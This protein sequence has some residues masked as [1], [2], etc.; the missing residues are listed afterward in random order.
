MKLPF[1]ILLSVLTLRAQEYRS[2]VIGNVT[3]STGAAIVKASISIRNDDTGVTAKTQSNAD[4]AFQLPYLLPGT[5]VLEV[6]H[7]GFKTHRRGP[8]ELRIDDRA[9]IDVALEV[10]RVS[11]QVTVTAETPQLKVDR[12]DVSTTLSTQELGG[13]PIL[14][15]NVT[16]MLLVTPGTQ[17]ND[18]THAAA[19]NP[20]GGYQIDVNGQQF[21]SNGFLLDGTENNSAILGIAVV[22]VLGLPPS[23]FLGFCIGMVLVAGR[24]HDP[25]RVSR[26]RPE[27][28]IAS[29]V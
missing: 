24:I 5:Y 26:E 23:L 19:E 8:I 22:A 20:Q 21:T 6:S 4:G 9:R 27:S 10:G 11:D 29:E 2:T 3:D 14:N 15:R 1:L 17:L 25:Y 7:A 13:L 16:Q 12:A 28:N 18:W